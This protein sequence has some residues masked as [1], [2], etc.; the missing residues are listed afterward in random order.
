MSVASL[1]SDILGPDVTVAFRAYDG[2]QF[3]PADART[4]IVVRSR[5]ALRRIV[6]APNELGFGRAYV[7]GDLEVDGDIFDVIS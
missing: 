7:A 1:L 4:T 2:T 3:G 5:D 6:T